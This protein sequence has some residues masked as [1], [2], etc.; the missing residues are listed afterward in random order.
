MHFI[1]N[2]SLVLHHP[3]EAERNYRAL[4]LPYAAGW[5]VLS[6]VVS[7]TCM[8]GAFFVMGLEVGWARWLGMK[9]G[10]GRSRRNL[11]VTAGGSSGR[12]GSQNRSDQS[13]MDEDEDLHNIQV[14]DLSDHA[15][16]DRPGE[17][18]SLDK[19]AVAKKSKL[20][21]SSSDQRKHALNVKLD[22]VVDK[23][24]WA[25]GWSMIDLGQGIGG[26]AERRRKKWEAT[27]AEVKNQELEAE[28]N[29]AE[30]DA[31]N[32]GQEN[33]TTTNQE[34]LVYHFRPPPSDPVASGYDNEI[35][36]DDLLPISDRRGSIWDGGR[37]PRK[38]S[39]KEAEEGAVPSPTTVGTGRYARRGSVP[40]LGDNK[41]RSRDRT[42]SLFPPNAVP[43]MSAPLSSAEAGSMFS[44]GFSFPGP[45]STLNSASLVSP[46]TTA[47]STPS[48]RYPPPSTLQGRRASVPVNPIYQREIPSTPLYTLARIQSYPEVDEEDPLTPAPHATDTAA[49][50]A[51]DQAAAADAQ[52]RASTASVSF[53]INDYGE[54]STT[55]L[56]RPGPHSAGDDNNQDPLLVDANGYARKSNRDRSI[57]SRASANRRMNKVRS[58]L[59]YDEVT[60]QEVR[61][62]LIAGT[63]CGWGIAGMR[64]CRSVQYSLHRVHSVR[65]C[66]L[67]VP[68]AFQ[69]TSA[70]NQSLVSPTSAT[71]S[72]M[73][74]QASS[75]PV[76]P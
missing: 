6:L 53:R 36:P 29:R 46:S 35:G 33:D 11:G 19:D 34:S 66:W 56:N 61:K 60:A 42:G 20:L 17:V 50:I 21:L 13:Q 51:N 70:R 41:V 27:Q 76:S 5:T 65:E 37:A 8:I 63:I 3:L 40:N 54:T 59:G 58:W 73:L 38:L 22:Q 69:I 62:I 32:H 7:C 30:G 2:N 1:G 18:L 44:P 25:L 74:S 14:T 68:F 4:T 26:R 48:S 9:L 72:A 12:R 28:Q 24:E 49:Q 55:A 75:L 23:L 52:R 64:K 45:G 10:R 15:L 31:G 16:R 39:G 67:I 47:P 71:R 57:R 43:P